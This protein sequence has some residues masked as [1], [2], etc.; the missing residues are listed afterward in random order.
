[1]R[2]GRLHPRS[3]AFLARSALKGLFQPKCLGTYWASWRLCLRH[4]VQNQCAPNC[5][6]CL[7]LAYDQDG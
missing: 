3:A 2:E 7:S 4:C 1:M 5:H 6:P